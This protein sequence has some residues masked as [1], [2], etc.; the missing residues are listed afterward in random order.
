[1]EFFRQEYWSGLP[2]PSLEDLPD[3]GI[4]PWSPELGDRA[5]IAISPK[6]NKSSKIL[7]K[8][9]PPP[10]EKW[11]EVLIDHI[12]YLKSENLFMLCLYSTGLP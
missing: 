6:Y 5:Q 9:L 7:A 11:G 4:E 2:F 10:L 12:F 1:M 8:I 3:P